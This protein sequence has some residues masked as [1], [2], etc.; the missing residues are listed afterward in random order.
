MRDILTVRHWECGGIKFPWTT[1]KSELEIV[2]HINLIQVEKI[3]ASV[4]AID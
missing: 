4:D 3:H 1:P 2:F